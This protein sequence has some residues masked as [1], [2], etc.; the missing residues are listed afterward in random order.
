MQDVFVR[1]EGAGTLLGRDRERGVLREL[2]GAARKGGSGVIVVH[3]DAGIGKTALLTDAISEASDLRVLQISGAESEMEMPYAAVHQLCAPLLGF[4]D[5]VPRPQANALRVALGFVA[6]VVPDRLLVSLA[7]LTLLAEAASERPIACIVDDAQWVDTASR[8]ALAF[9]ARRILADPVVMVFAVRERG[10]QSELAGLPD[11]MLRGLDAESAR[12]LLSAMVPGRLDEQVRESLLA[13]ANGNPLA[14]SELHK[15]LR[16]AELAGGYGLASAV[17]TETRIERLAIGRIRQLPSDT[18]TLLLI[19]AVEPAGR[20]E[21]LWSAAGHLGV[22]MAD[23]APAEDAGLVAVDRGIRFRHPLIRAAIFRNASAVQRRRVHAALASAITDPSASDYRAWHRAHATEG[24]DEQVADELERAAD[25]ARAR[26]GVAAAAEFLA[27]ATRLTP[28][29]SRRAR[30]ALDAAQAKLEAGLPDAAIQQLA[31]AGDVADDEL[32]SARIELVHARLV[33]AARRGGEAPQLLLAAAT[34]LAHVDGELSRETY[35]EAISAA[36]L[37]GRLTTRHQNSARIIAKA[38]LQAPASPIPPRTVDLMLDG[39]IT[40][41]TDSYVAA[42]PRV[43]KA[44]REFGRHDPAIVADP[45]WHDL[46]HRACLDVFDMETYDTLV[47]GQVAALRKAGTLSALPVALATYASWCVTT[48]RFTEAAASLDES[49]AIMAATGAPVPRSSRAYLGAY[50]GDEDGHQLMQ[51]SIEGATARGEGFDVT[52]ALYASAILHNGRG[53][54]PEAVAAASAGARYDDIGLYGF[55]LV[56]LVEAAARNGQ[57]EVAAEALG[58]LVERTSASGTPTA[59]G[60]ASRSVAFVA[61]GQEADDAY[62]DAIL[63]LQN[64]PVVVY[65]ARTHLAYGE[66]LRRQK[67]RAQARTQLRIAHEMFTSMGAHSFATRARRELNAAGEAVHESR[68]TI[69]SSLTAQERHI[70]R[71]AREGYT[72]SEIASQLFI[73][74]RTVEWHLRKVFMKLGIA[75]R[76]DLRAASLDLSD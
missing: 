6:G 38:A 57:L 44:V 33:L 62:Q 7:V 51:T 67:H 63:N 76:R 32:L 66:W 75:S 53:R 8:Q 1:S 54:Y 65:L 29:P 12:S 25:R 46:S 15:E 39:L 49:A 16:P 28:D 9:V 10:A 3:G 20:P 60:M 35:L 43:L 34:R 47:S 55:H 56:E 40:R 5:R 45:R 11:L 69:A 24:T 73:S 22:G 50:R 74:A 61:D 42:A 64:S 26:G 72:N 30:R 13:E 41:L 48:G 70:A 71:L 37:A 59:L 17:S 21:W 4:I 23:T 27:Y 19:A 2:F 31:N 52:V 18:Q 58:R 36:I 68:P 14:L